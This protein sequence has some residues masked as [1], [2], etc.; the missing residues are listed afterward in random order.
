MREKYLDKKMDC[1][2]RPSEERPVKNVPLIYST[3][4]LKYYLY[5][6]LLQIVD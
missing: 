3:V 1:V 2:N 5:E 6:S 4:R